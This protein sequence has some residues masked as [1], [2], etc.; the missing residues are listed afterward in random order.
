M[1]AYQLSV[2]I[3]SIVNIF[4]ENKAN[5]SQVSLFLLQFSYTPW[6]HSRTHCN[7]AEHSGIVFWCVPMSFDVV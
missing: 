5:L 3:C 1:S 6:E 4:A 2:G 7:T